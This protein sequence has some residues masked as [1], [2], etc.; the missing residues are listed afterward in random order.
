[1]ISSARLLVWDIQLQYYVLRLQSTNGRNDIHKFIE[2]YL[3]PQANPPS[4]PFLLGPKSPF[5][6]A[7]VETKKKGFQKPQLLIRKFSF[8]LTD[9]HML[10][11]INQ[12]LLHLSI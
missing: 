1:M 8:T 4:L 6:E 7:Y 10:A 3:Q 12:V 9:Y 11:K 2:Q 5:P